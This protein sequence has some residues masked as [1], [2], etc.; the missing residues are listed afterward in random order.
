MHDPGNGSL[1]SND[2]LRMCFVAC[3]NV[4]GIIKK[5]M[6]EKQKERKEEK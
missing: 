4:L 2:S 1:V 3:I 5:Y 6:K